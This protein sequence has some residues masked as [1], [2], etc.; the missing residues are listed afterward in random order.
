VSSV[1][2]MLPVTITMRSVSRDSAGRSVEG[3]P[4]RRQ[5]RA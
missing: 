5:V 2:R 1:P 3:A 4:D